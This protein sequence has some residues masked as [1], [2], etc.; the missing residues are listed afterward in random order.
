MYTFY[1]AYLFFLGSVVVTAIY[2]KC[3]SFFYYNFIPVELSAILLFIC[4]KNTKI[5]SPK[6]N[7]I[8]ASVFGIYLISADPFISNIL[9]SRIL[10]CADYYYSPFFL[11]HM[12]ISLV[13]IFS[14]CLIIET[15]RQ[16]L[17]IILR[18]VW[19]YRVMA[20][21]HRLRHYYGLAFSD[22]KNSLKT[23]ITTFFS[24]WQT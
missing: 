22:D 24:M 20:I 10:H 21:S 7:E 6:I 8:A 16:R 23:K 15:F 18:S 3:M 14:F 2:K 4:F 17:F 1:V 13:G 12:I 19:N 9:Y 5:N 11:L